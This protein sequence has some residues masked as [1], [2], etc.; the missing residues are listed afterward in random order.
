VDHIA[1]LKDI[2]LLW[3]KNIWQT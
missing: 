1:L 2:F 3:H